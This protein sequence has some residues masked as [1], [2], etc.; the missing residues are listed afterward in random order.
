MTSN[1]ADDEI[2]EL[3]MSSTPKKMEPEQKLQ[4][5][6]DASYLNQSSFRSVVPMATHTLDEH[7]AGTGAFPLGMMSPLN[8]TGF[9]GAAKTSSVPRPSYDT[10]YD[11]S[12]LGV[13]ERD[14]AASISLLRGGESVDHL[15]QSTPAPQ[16]NSSTST[17]QRTM[18]QQQHLLPITYSS[19]EIKLDRCM[20]HGSE[21]KT[22]ATRLELEAARSGSGKV[23]VNDLTLT[24][25]YGYGSNP[26]ARASIPSSV[27]TTL[28]EFP[29]IF[30]GYSGWVCRHCSHFAH[31]HR[32]PNYYMQGE[33]PPPNDFVDEHLSF[34]PALNYNWSLF[35]L[36]SM[37]KDGQCGQI[38]IQ[39]PREEEE[40]AEHTTPEEEKKPPRKRQHAPKD[41]RPT[42]LDDIK[43][44]AQAVETYKK[45]LSLLQKRADKLP[46]PS[47]SDDIGS[48]LVQEEDT[49]LLTDYFYH[50]ACQLVVCRFNEEDRKTRG[51]KRKNVQLGFGGLQCIHC[52]ST[53]SARKFFWSSVDRLSNSFSEIPAHVLKCK[54]CPIEVTEALLVLKG[55]H[56]SQMAS[57]PRGSQKIFLRRMWRRLH[58]GNAVEARTAGKSVHRRLQGDD[59]LKPPPEND[60]ALIPTGEHVPLL[61]AV[62]QDKDWLSD[63][64]CFVRKQIE[65]F[66]A[67]K[68][69][70]EHALEE[71]K[72][73]IL[74]GQVGLRCLH[75]AKLGGGSRGDAVTYPCAVSGIYDSVKELQR[76][77]F[78]T[79]S[80]LPLEL[81]RQR[82]NLTRGASSL[83][84]VLRRYYVQA[85]RAIGLYDSAEGGIL[86][87]TGFSGFDLSGKQ[88][89]E[90]N[91]FD[92]KGQD[93]EKK[94]VKKARR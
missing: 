86:I 32:G 12:T 34:C 93:E 64:D 44:Q 62:T 11:W 71:Q 47:I 30:D 49:T 63:L 87:Q 84:S 16:K 28:K 7:T 72:Y 94:A 76:R 9:R 25:Q 61:L 4:Q 22:F 66:S 29:F 13:D 70:V 20:T 38:P 57:L 77:H 74:I 8:A 1:A 17:D 78:D 18:T 65:V 2:I 79:C 54:S 68:A 48:T 42:G 24:P 53:P 60:S 5:G 55:L 41:S 3:S 75:C 43:P 21:I 52:A 33:K 27:S 88:E 83:S 45:A 50:I 40:E 91:V 80:S 36:G 51:N 73:P 85:A 10:S 90:T 26:S 37:H 82:S 15:S 58:D 6:L 69:D 46:R 19:P 67:G 39:H 89:Q 31:Y 56:S 59:A 92:S 35:D 14:A 81:K 23:K